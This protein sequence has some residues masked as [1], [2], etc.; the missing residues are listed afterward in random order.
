MKKGK[1]SLRNWLVIFALAIGFVFTLAACDGQVKQE[2]TLRHGFYQSEAL[3][4]N[5]RLQLNI[6]QNQ[7][8][9]TM[10][11]DNR[12]VNEGT[13]QDLPEGDYQLNGNQQTDLLTVANGEATVL[14]P[15]LNGDERIVL[16]YIDSALVSFDT[17]FDDV[18]TYQ[19]LI[20]P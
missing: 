12:L 8:T 3:V 19:A 20:K 18:E 9:F 5:H 6:D 7:Q 2:Q 1:S 17:E 4:D 14:F 15:K 13:Y 10:Y 11:I 16:M